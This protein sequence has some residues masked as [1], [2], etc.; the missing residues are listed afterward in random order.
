MN[1]PELG[2]KPRWL[3]EEHRVKEIFDAMIRYSENSQVIPVD[4]IFELKDIVYRDNEI[5][6]VKNWYDANHVTPCNAK[7]ASILTKNNEERIGYYEDGEWHSAYGK[8]LVA[9]DIEV[10]RWRNV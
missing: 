5:N 9:D 1:K 10:I 7:P 2:L 4:W 6:R 8:P 3:H